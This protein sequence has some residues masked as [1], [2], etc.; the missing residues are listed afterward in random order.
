M[1]IDIFV[2]KNVYHFEIRFLNHKK[3]ETNTIYME[4]LMDMEVLNVQNL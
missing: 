2:S 3:Q 1:R 4:F